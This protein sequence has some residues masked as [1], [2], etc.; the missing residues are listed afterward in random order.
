MLPDRKKM[1]TFK[2]DMEH[3]VSISFLFL[4]KVTFNTIILQ[5][6][7]FYFPAIFIVQ[8]SSRSN[9]KYY[10]IGSLVSLFLL[11]YY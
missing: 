1:D 3:A 4:K 7:S 9:R 6:Y 5:Q 10:S 8:R 2:K 11:L